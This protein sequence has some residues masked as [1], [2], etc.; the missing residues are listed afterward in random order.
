[1]KILKSK[2]GLLA[3]FLFLISVSIG[4]YLFFFKQSESNMKS[5][6]VEVAAENIS[7]LQFEELENKRIIATYYKDSKRQEVTVHP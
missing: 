3:L 6:F 4:V 5:E 1:M 2:I 7:D